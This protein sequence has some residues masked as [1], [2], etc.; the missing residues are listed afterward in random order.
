MPISI[1]VRSDA[2]NAAAIR[3]LWTAV[4]VLED[5][6]S[7]ARLGYP[8]HLTLA[9]YDH[10]DVELARE[11]VHEVFAGIGPQR[12]AFDSLDRFETPD[13]VVLW[14]RPRH[15]DDLI[16]AHR[17][18]HEAIGVTHSY[19][20]YQ[21]GHW[22]PHCSLA[23]SIPRSRRDEALELVRAGTDPFEVTFDVADV[24]AFMPVE[25]LVEHPLG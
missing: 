19:S 3:G 2:D 24:V 18:I 6:P 15:I 13:T 16:E 1:N 23:T 14:A 7:M 4:S 11:V 25:V 9:V 22:V 17:R 21:P 10:L 12:V 5:E 20:N 8:P